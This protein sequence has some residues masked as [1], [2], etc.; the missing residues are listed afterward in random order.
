[1]VSIFCSVQNSEAQN[2][3]VGIGTLTPNSSAMLD[4]VSTTKGVLVPRMNTAQMNAITTP[5]NGLM[6]YNTDSLCFC[7]YKSVAWTSLC[8]GGGSGGAGPTGPTGPAGSA[9]ATG[10]TGSAGATG[11]TGSAGATG[12]TGPS[13]SNGATGPT[14]PSGSNGA[15]GPTGP[16]GPSQT[17][18]WILGNAGTSAGTNF[19]G[20]T[21]AQDFVTK[22]NNVERMR[23]NVGGPVITNNPT[24]AAGDVFSVYGTGYAGAISPLGD[25]AI[26][27]YVSGTGA[28]VYGEQTS[29]GVGVYG[30]NTAGGAGVYGISATNYG[31]IGVANNTNVSG[32][33]GAN[34][35]TGGVGIIALGNAVTPGSAI[36][37]GCGMASNG[38][39]FGGFSLATTAASG[40]GFIG[41]GNNSATS[42]SSPSGSGLA[43]TGI[44]YGVA[45][46]ATSAASGTFAGYFDANSTANGYA[47]VGGTFGGTDYA[48]NSAGTKATQVKDLSGKM[49]TMFCPEAPEVLFQDFGTSQLVNGTA[50]IDMDPIFSK[51][52][53][54]DEKHPIKVF[55]QLEG[56]CKGVYVTNKSEKGFDV[57]EL[58][59]GNSNVKFSWQVVANRADT[60]DENGNITSLFATVRFPDAPMRMK[61]VKTEIVPF[62]QT[63]VL[64]NKTK[65]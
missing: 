10:A 53:Q 3:N 14:G 48:I 31:V 41:V 60:K 46:F 38:T 35:N 16:T 7:Y 4:V 36:T 63:T 25:Y 39:S 20:T 49:R 34:Q 1:M 37:G 59:S 28:A 65:K 56:D 47:F 17:A 19:V 27:G 24:P 21:D 33:R 26:N 50:H 23:V 64:F 55:I 57:I 40:N 2:Q 22:T 51:N 13:G 52:I 45:G 15:T 54:I 61:S 30:N 29:T 12:A 18:W 9:G 8:G 44:T 5:A 32:V 43:G 62:G 42:F 6:I 58:G 11:A